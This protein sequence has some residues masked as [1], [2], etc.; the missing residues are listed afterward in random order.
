MTC[1]TPSAAEIE[2]LVGQVNTL[3][4]NAADVQNCDAE[5]QKQQIIDNLKTN[6]E[7]SRDNYT[8]CEARFNGD[9]RAYIVE[10]YGVSY[11][12]QQ[13]SEKKN[14]ALQGQR[15]VLIN[16]FM[17]KMTE[18]NNNFDDLQNDVNHLK[19]IQDMYSNTGVNKT[20]NDVFGV[21]ISP[22]EKEGFRTLETINQEIT[23]SFK[24]NETGKFINKI[25]YIIYYLL[26]VSLIAYISI[27][28][29]YGVKFIIPGGIFLLILPLLGVIKFFIYL[30]SLA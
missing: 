29:L 15:D 2:A 5:C 28:K 12:N 23:F 24:K 4:A 30:K 26:V 13:E 17:E 10:K 3:V 21:T 20:L 14:K 1:P 7:E 8:S 27:Y 9:E 11:Y 16:S 18:T 25:L 22:F 6:L 19:L